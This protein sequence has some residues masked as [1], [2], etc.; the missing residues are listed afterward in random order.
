MNDLSSFSIPGLSKWR[1]ANTNVLES[2]VELLPF[3]AL[4]VESQNHLILLANPPAA[5]LTGYTRAELAGLDMQNLLVDWDTL[6]SNIQ[7]RPDLPPPEDSSSVTQ[8]STTSL[9]NRRNQPKIKVQVIISRLPIH[10]GLSGAERQLLVFIGQN[11]TSPLNTLMELS[12]NGPEPLA[13]LFDALTQNQ[14]EATLEKVLQAGKQVLQDNTLAIFLQADYPNETSQQSSQLRLKTSLGA[15]QFWP[16][17]LPISELAQLRQMPEWIHGKRPVSSIQR[18]ARAVGLAFL[19]SAPLGQPGT[20]VGVLLIAGN[21]L[22][23]ANASAFLVQLL[24]RAATTALQQQTAHL[25]K[26]LEQQR[27]QARL[28]A[29]SILQEKMSEAALL[30]SPAL[31]VLYL[32]PAAETMMGYSGMDITGQPIENILIGSESLIQDLETALKGRLI[33]PPVDA[34]LYRRSGEAFLAQVRILPITHESH[35]E[36]VLV[37]LQDLSEQERV[38]IQ[39][40]QLEQRAMLGE[41]TAVFAHEV[42][43]PINNI[44]TGLQLLEMNLAPDDSNRESIARMLQDCDRLAEL[45]KSV[46]TFSRPA[47]YEMTALDL[48]LLLRRLLERLQ[49]RLTRLNIQHTLQVEPDCPPALGNL[50]ALE[51]VFSNLIGNALQAMGESGGRLGIKVHTSISLENRQYLEISVADTGPGIPHEIQ[52]RIFQPFFTTE[53]SGTGL[54]LAITKRIVTAHKGSIRVESVPGGAA[55]CVQIPAASNPEHRL[56]QS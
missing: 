16:S 8:V 24:S 7:E 23:Q 37:L 6:M 54:G 28:R 42:R 45:M 30:L 11:L 12:S 27:M 40:Q 19:V 13:M 53:R 2:L 21:D 43:N 9:L 56:A 36:E 17:E 49:P 38:Q 35:L 20:Q 52:E 18:S 29:N 39:T 4:S 50:R 15:A 48:P 31:R 41:V 3:A 34:R 1:A 47:E 22:T 26:Q 33:F 14:P 46:L 44:S 5:E 55:F 25:K 32:N 10:S 51:Q